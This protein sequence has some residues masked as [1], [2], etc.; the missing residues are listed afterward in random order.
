MEGVIRFSGQLPG[1]VDPLCTDL[2]AYIKV[3]VKSLSSFKFAH[4]TYLL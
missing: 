3:R 2:T 1:P 4:L